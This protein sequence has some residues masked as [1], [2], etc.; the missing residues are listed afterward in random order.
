MQQSIA[1]VSL[2]VRDYD[3]AIAFYTKVLRFALIDIH[4]KLRA[5][6]QAVMSHTGQ[7]GIFASQF[8]QFIARC[9]E[10]IMSNA[11]MILK[12]HIKTGRTA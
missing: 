5:I 9:H 2:L 11:R 12:L 10:C 3:E 1:H 4:L 8:Q 7:R 6:V